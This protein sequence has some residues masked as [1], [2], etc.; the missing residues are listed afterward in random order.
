MQGGNGRIAGHAFVFRQHNH[1]TTPPN[2]PGET[3]E[4]V[5]PPPADRVEGDMGSYV[6]LMRKAGF[7]AGGLA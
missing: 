7:P 4:L 2:R 1:A 3:V 6:E 5:P